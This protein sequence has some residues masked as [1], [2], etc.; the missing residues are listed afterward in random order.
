[1]NKLVSLKLWTNIQHSNFS[2]KAVDKII[3]EVEAKKTLLASAVP[4]LFFADVIEQI[5]LF[6]LAIPSAVLINLAK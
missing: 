4:R 1:M 5:S 6:D 2:S 3:A